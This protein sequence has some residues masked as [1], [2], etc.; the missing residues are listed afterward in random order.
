MAITLAWLG[1]LFVC[2]SI[3]SRLLGCFK[4]GR[5]GYKGFNNSLEQGILSKV[6]GPC[7]CA[8]FA[9]KD[10]QWVRCN[11]EGAPLVKGAN[12][13]G[14]SFDSLSLIL[15]AEYALDQCLKL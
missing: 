4:L 11:E 7:L 9:D 2:C 6:N 12:E 5:L 1:S 8:F 3:R 15:I 14:R 10:P 13:L